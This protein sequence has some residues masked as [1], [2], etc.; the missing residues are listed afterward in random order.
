MGSQHQLK[1]EPVYSNCRFNPNPDY[2]SMSP[3]PANHNY[4][5]FNQYDS[6]R[7]SDS[8]A[9]TSSTNDTNSTLNDSPSSVKDDSPALRA[10]LSRPVDQ[11]ITYEYTEL[12]KGANY[13]RDFRGSRDSSEFDGEEKELVGFGKDDSLEEKTVDD[14]LAAVQGNFYPWMKSTHGN[15][16]SGS[17]GS[18][19]T[20]QTYTRFQTLELEKE[21]HYNKYLTRKRRIEIAHTLCLSERQIKIWFQ[22]RRMKAKKDGKFGLHSTEFQPIEDIN[23]NQNLFC[24][25]SRFSKAFYPNGGQGNAEKRPETSTVD[26]DRNCYENE[27]AMPLT[28]LKNLPGPPLSP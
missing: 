14:N 17:K 25:S 26:N 3:P 7:Q 4:N 23:M 1:Q 27:L 8:L 24:A 19:R 15:S 10:L 22:N 2:S 12:R 18:K 9:T 20:R 21:F 16:E 6:C 5:S 13:V 28:A 11:K